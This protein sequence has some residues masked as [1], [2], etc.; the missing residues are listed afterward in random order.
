MGRCGAGQLLRKYLLYQYHF[1]YG[2]ASVYGA[3]A[4][5]ERIHLEN[6]KFELHEN[7]FVKIDPQR[8]TAANKFFASGDV[9]GQPMLAHKASHEGRVAVD[10]IGGSKTAYQTTREQHSPTRLWRRLKESTARV[11]HSS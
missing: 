5:Q 11:S 3:Q 7:R 6:T 10:A 8:C 2:Y 9:A 1:P 4:Q